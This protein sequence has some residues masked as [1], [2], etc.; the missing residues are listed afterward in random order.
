[1][2]PQKREKKSKV[3]NPVDPEQ[4]GMINKLCRWRSSFAFF[5]LVGPYL[6]P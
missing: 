4:A 5:E 2:K 6:L 3:F 1:M